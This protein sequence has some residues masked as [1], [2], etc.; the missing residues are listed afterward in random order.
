MQGFKPQPLLVLLLFVIAAFVIIGAGP[1]VVPMAG[2]FDRPEAAIW[3]IIGAALMFALTWWFVRRDPYARAML[4][5]GLSG[6]NVRVL[7]GWTLVGAAI[8]LGWLLL[9]RTVQP[10]HIEAGTMTA[11]GFGFSVLVYL[12]GSIIEELAFRGY[13]FL[14]LRR[15][16]GVIAAVVIASLAFGLFHFPGMHGLALLKM[17]ATAGLCSVIFCL[18]FLRAGTL[19]AAIALHAGL[20]ITLHSILG[21]GDTNRASLLRVV[22]DGPAPGWDVWF[23]SFMLAGSIAAIVLALG[24]RKT[25][26][27]DGISISLPSASA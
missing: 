10:F 27:D 20:N 19:W 16:Y 6:R 26:G 1:M 22:P 8:I 25:A 17:V 15:A 2:P 13:P 21:A 9:F 18:G 12:F 3:K 24:L 14:R 7:L 23:W 4:D 5:L 11:T